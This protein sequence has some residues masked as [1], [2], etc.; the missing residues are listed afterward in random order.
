MLSYQATGAPHEAQWE[1]GRTTERPRGCSSVGGQRTMQTLAKLPNRAPRTAAV[2]WP[3][4]PSRVG[5]SAAAAC[6]HIAS[7]VARLT[8][9]V[10]EAMNASRE[11]SRDRM[12]AV[13][14]GGAPPR[15]VRIGRG[16][17]G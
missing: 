15:G 4:Q 1:P 8:G 17:L 6:G 3:N 13:R 14:A 9:D 5:S 16:A 7:T 2:A 12:S 11:E 10:E